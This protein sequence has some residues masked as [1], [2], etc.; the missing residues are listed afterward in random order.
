MDERA[1]AG[2]RDSSPWAWECRLWALKLLP[3]MSRLCHLIFEV[4][5]EMLSRSRAGWFFG[6][7]MMKGVSSY[8]KCHLCLQKVPMSDKRE[9]IRPILGLEQ[10]VNTCPFSTSSWRSF[11]LTLYNLVSVMEDLQI[12]KV[13]SWEVFALVTSFDSS[14]TESVPLNS[15]IPVFS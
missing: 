2:G 8:S 1:E 13:L 4:L 10:K 3:M 12:R 9:L 14:K 5:A 7:M 15:K 6:I 11:W